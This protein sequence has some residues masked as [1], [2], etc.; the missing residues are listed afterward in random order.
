MKAKACV[1]TL[2]R[3]RERR[4]RERLLFQVPGNQ[5]SR[6]EAPSLQTMEMEH[7]LA[8]ARSLGESQNLGKRL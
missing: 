6:G 4:R 8:P 3:G 1:K 7:D 5:I 2:E